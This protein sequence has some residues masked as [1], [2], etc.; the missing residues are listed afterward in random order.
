MAQL[1]IRENL[2]TKDDS[3]SLV[4]VSRM[5]NPRSNKIIYK[6]VLIS[7]AAASQLLERSRTDTRTVSVTQPQSPEQAAGRNVH[8]E[9]A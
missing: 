5:G 4:K 9:L 7:E 6:V 1:L 8:F 3:D 2:I